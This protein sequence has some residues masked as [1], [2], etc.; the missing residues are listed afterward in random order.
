MLATGIV[1]ASIAEGGQSC[2][3]EGIDF[4]EA[5]HHKLCQVGIQTPDALQ[6]D[7]QTQSPDVSSNVGDSDKIFR[8]Y[9]S[10]TGSIYSV[11]VDDASPCND[12]GG[13]A[14][15]T[16]VQSTPTGVGSG[17]GEEFF[18]FLDSS[19]RIIGFGAKIFLDTF[20]GGFI[21]DVLGTGIVGVEF[22]TAFLDGIK[23]LIGLAI[24]S[25]FGYLFIGKPLI[26]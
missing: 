9:T 23:I 15:C 2:P 20:T 11:L 18:S 21:L 14:N 22:P 26:E 3:A 12:G 16:G 17:F 24:A 25:Y 19:G 6:F 8:N 10:P 4:N 7:A 5:I 13:S 1:E